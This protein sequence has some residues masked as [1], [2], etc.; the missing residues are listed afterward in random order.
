MLP[1]A[2]RHRMKR[3]SLIAVIAV[4]STASA[5]VAPGY[6][7]ARLA[8][9]AAITRTSSKYRSMSSS[10]SSA[11][12]GTTSTNAQSNGHARGPSMLFERPKVANDVTELIGNTPL[13]RLNRVTVG[14]Q[15]EVLAKLESMEPCN[16]V[17]D[18]IA[19]SMITEAENRGEI[20][21]GK[22]VLVEPT[23]GN[24]GIGLAMVAAAKGYELILTMPESMS[25]ERRVLL[26]AFGANLVLTVAS[27]GMKGAIAKAQEIVDSLGDKAF[28]LQQFENPDNPKI[29]LETTGPEIWTDTDGQVDILV[30]GV[31]TGGTMTGCAQ[32]LKGRKSSLITVAVEP[33]ESAV[34]SGDQPGPHKIQGIG[35]GFVPR[36]AD[37]SMFDEIQ[38]VS[39]EESIDMARELAKKEGLLV[40]ISSGAAVT[41]AIRVGSRPENANKKIVV[42]IPSFGERYLSTALFQTLWDDAAKMVTS[43]S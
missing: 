33:R 8:A 40:G 21:P 26:K 22:T 1:R 5:F 12:R 13:V 3:Q 28:M 36:N 11:N 24:T 34:L 41:A 38:Q 20:A 31:G 7:A 14:C 37:M 23:S 19:Y 42:I 6:H 10:P 2:T 29:H 16:S 27:K 4:A 9:A 35:A 43:D 25:M 30:G 39:S 17:K 18:R 15:A 32:Y